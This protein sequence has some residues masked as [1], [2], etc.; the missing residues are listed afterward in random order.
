MHNDATGRFIRAWLFES[1]AGTS[2]GWPASTGGAVSTS[3]SGADNTAGEG[4]A[5]C[6]QHNKCSNLHLFKKYH[7]SKIKCFGK[8]LWWSVP[9]RASRG[10]AL[11][12][13]AHAG[14]WAAPPVRQQRRTVLADRGRS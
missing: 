11:E 8:L 7:K 5:T 12:Q 9:R 1:R 14:H 4:A 6:A 2:V 10:L 3:G 13:R